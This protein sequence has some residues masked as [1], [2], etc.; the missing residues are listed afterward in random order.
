MADRERL[1][2]YVPVR[3]GVICRD[4]AV[5]CAGSQPGEPPHPQAN[6]RFMAVAYMTIGG[7]QADPRFQGGVH[8]PPIEVRSIG[9]EDPDA[10]RFLG[11]IYSN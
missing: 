6:C 11:L 2:N 10:A 3:I 5:P 7:E 9:L 4:I 8:D 1:D